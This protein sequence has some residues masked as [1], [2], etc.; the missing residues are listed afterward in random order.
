V[1]I[2]ESQNQ[3]QYAMNTITGAWCNYTGWSANCLEMFNDEPY[4]GGDGYV[5]HAWYGSDDDGNNITAL[6]LQAFNNFNGAGRL[7]RFTMSR[8][9]FRTDGAPAIYAGINIDFNTDAPT[10]SL[11]FTPSTYSQ[12]DSALWDA[13]TWGGALSILQNWQGLNG[14]GYYGAPIV[15]TAA[16][17]IQVRWVATD[18]VIEGGAIL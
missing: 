2:Q 6:G 15:K 3:Q 13:G 14:V 10:A 5:A 7:K 9:I 4:F 18:I 17:G 12:W 8:P 16:S 11:N 1:P